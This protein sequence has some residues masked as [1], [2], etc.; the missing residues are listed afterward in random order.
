MISVCICTYNRSKSLRRTLESL[1]EQNDLDFGALE[2]LIIDNNCTDDTSD[3]VDAFQKKL[4]IRR[5]TESC[6]GLSHARNRAVVEFQGDVLL[7][8]DD[9]VRLEP[10]WFA[11]YLDAIRLF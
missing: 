11:A 1:V 3:V 7:F 5:I 10:S 8:T 6:Q 9:D 4:P 2:I